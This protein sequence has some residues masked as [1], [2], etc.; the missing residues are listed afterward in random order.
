MLVKP[1]V[2]AGLGLLLQRVQAAPQAVPLESDL[3]SILEKIHADTPI[4]W[5]EVVNAD[6]SKSNVTDIDNTIWD[7]AVAQLVPR[8]VAVAKRQSRSC[9]GSGSWAKQS[10]LKDGVSEACIY[11]SECSPFLQP[12]RR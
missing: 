6:G 8:N 1:A 10:V 3:I 11:L 2:L 4:V 12:T 7:D 9:F 5:H